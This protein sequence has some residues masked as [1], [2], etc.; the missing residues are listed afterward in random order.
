MIFT[1]PELKIARVQSLSNH[2]RFLG[3][4]CPAPRCLESDFCALEL[5]LLPNFPP[6][7]GAFACNPAPKRQIAI[8]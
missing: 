4:F 5:H 6:P 7:S 2:W 1:P 3:F 8:S